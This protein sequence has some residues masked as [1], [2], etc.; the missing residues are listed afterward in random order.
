MPVSLSDTLGNEQFVNMP[1]SKQLEFLRS[2]NEAFSKL[3]PKD[4]GTVLFKSKQQFRP[5]YTKEQSVREDPGFW[6]TLGSYLS[7]TIQAPLHPVQSLQEATA[8]RRADLEKSRDASSPIERAA[9]AVTGRLPFVGPAI[10][11]LGESIG[12]GRY[13]EA[14]AEALMLAS[15]KILPPV[16]HGVGRVAKPYIRPGMGQ[17]ASGLGLT[18]YGAAEMLQGRLGGFFPAYYGVRNLIGGIKKLGTPVAKE[19]NVPQLQE[20]VKSGAMSMDEFESELKR[21]GYSPKSIETLSKT[22]TPK[23]ISPLEVEKPGKI[24]P[25][26]TMSLSRM[27]EAV[28]KGQ[29]TIDDYINYL[30]NKR[31]VPQDID[32]LVESLKEKMLKSE[33]QPFDLRSIEVKRPLATAETPF[34]VQSLKAESPVETSSLKVR[35]PIE[36]PVETLSVKMPEDVADERLIERAARVEAAGGDPQKVIRG[37]KLDYSKF[38]DEKRYINSL[39]IARHIMSSGKDLPEN[40]D[41][42]KAIAKEAGANEPSIRGAEQIRS[43]VRILSKKKS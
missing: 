10:S 39:K 26:T 15:P 42:W 31:M 19:L 41:A 34:N 13:G 27:E 25:S 17:V 28:I 7:S 21:I 38:H 9:Y 30:K 5:D 33:E 3:N 43:L 35:S 16:A 2:N 12:E 11:S 37:E 18:G 20:A 29:Q 14:G 23:T 32:T 1:L 6:N 40:A 22:L 24:V 8:A 4:Q 36:S